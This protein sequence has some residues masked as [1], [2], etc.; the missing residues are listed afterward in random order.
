VKAGESRSDTDTREPA[1]CRDILTKTALQALLAMQ[2]VEGSNPF[3]RF[4]EGPHLQ[5]FFVRESA[6][7]FASPGTQWVPG[8]QHAAGASQNKSVCRH[9]LM[10]RTIDLLFMASASDAVAGAHA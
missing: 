2:K 6:G 10:T 3:S 1:V 4:Q 5:V 8:G 9:F 7:A